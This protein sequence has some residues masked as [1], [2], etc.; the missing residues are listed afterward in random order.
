MP[1][2]LA[3]ALIGLITIGVHGYAL[4]T[5]HAKAPSGSLD[6]K[7]FVG[8]IGPKGGKADGQDEIVFLNGQFLS[9]GCSEYGFGSAPYDVSAS[10]DRVAFKAVT[11]S[12]KHGQ[13]E[14]EGQIQGDRLEATY[15]WTKK[16][17]YWFDAHEEHWFKGRLRTE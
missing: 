1:R 8:H 3:I 6:G 2:V 14:W 5:D 10:G 15:L 11:L 17:W 9:T 7:V 4:G 13:I 12:P 16:R